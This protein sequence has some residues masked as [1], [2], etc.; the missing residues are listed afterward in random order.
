MALEHLYFHNTH[1]IRRNHCMAEEGPFFNKDN[2][3]YN[4]YKDLH[5]TISITATCTTG[6]SQWFDV[7]YY[8][9][10]YVEPT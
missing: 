2:E 3:R 9:T 5:E 7:L 4:V 8:E 6:D 10:L 1:Y